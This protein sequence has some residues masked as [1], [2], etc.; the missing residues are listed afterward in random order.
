MRIVASVF[1][2][3][4]FIALCAV[5]EPAEAFPTK[6]TP[7]LT[8]PSLEYSGNIAIA[9]LNSDTMD[10]IID[11]SDYSNGYSAAIYYQK[12]S[13]PFSAP[14]DR[15][16]STGQDP[17]GT[18]IG[19]LNNDTLNDVIIV[20]RQANRIQ[21]HYQNPDH[22]INESA[23]VTI[24]TG[25]QPTDVEIADVNNDTLNDI[26]CTNKNNGI[27][28]IHYQ[29]DNNT[30]NKTVGLTLTTGGNPYFI[31]TG[32]LNDDGLIDIIAV[33]PGSDDGHIFYQ[34]NDNLFNTT[35]DWTLTS[36]GTPYAV[37]IEDMNDDDLNDIVI[38]DL[39]TVNPLFLFYQ[40]NDNTFSSTPD[41]TISI[42]R[43]VRALEVGDLN[44][45][46]LND[47]VA[48]NAYDPFYGF[49]Y[50]QNQD[51]TMPS[52]PDVTLT[53]GNQPSSVG[54]GYLNDDSYI[55]IAITHTY[56]DD[57]R[58][59]FGE[60][61]VV[62]QPPE[63]KILFPNGG[64]MLSGNL[65]ILWNG[66]D[67]D[68][69][70]VD[71]E[72]YLST[73]GGNTWG[74]PI[75]NTT[76]IE[77]PT[78]IT[79]IWDQFNT[80]S[81]PDSNICLIKITAND[82]MGPPVEVN[83]SSFFIIDNNPPVTNHD[84]NGLW[85]SSDFQITL[86]ATDAGSG[87]NNTFYM[88]NGGPINSVSVNG[89][90]QI[91]TEGTA[92]TLEYWSDDNVFNLE[93]HNLLM[94]IKL[95]KTQPTSSDDYDDLWHTSAFTISLSAFDGLSG[96]D[97]IYYRIN[98]GPI[99]S[100]SVNGPPQIT[101]EG[102]TNTLEYW[103]VD[104]ASN[105]EVHN[106]LTDIK[107][108]M[109]PP[110]TTDDYDG[111]WHNTPFTINLSASDNG[112]GVDETYYRI[113]GGPIN[114]V[115]ADGQPQI[116]TEGASNTLEYWSVDNILNEEIHKMLM[117]IKL[118]MTSPTSSDDY[119]GLWHNSS[120]TIN[121]SAIDGLSGVDD[122]YYRINGG[123]I[124]SVSVD[125]QPQITTEGASNTLEY[126]SVD[127][128]LNEEI[129]NIL[130]DIKL[131][132]TPPIT[133]PDYDGL[134]HNS[135]FTIYLSA[136][137]SISGIDEIYY[138][139]NGGPINS[140]S[141]D[142]QPIITTEGA[143]NTLEYWSV[144]NASNE[145]IHNLLT[146]IKF[147]TT[148]PISIHDYD[149]EWN[150]MMAVINLAAYDDLSGVDDIFYR[151][152]NGAV[153]SRKAH[154]QPI[155][156]T[157]GNANTLEFWAVDN[158]SNEESPHNFI[159]D[160]KLDGIIPCI[161]LQTPANCSHIPAGRTIDFEIVETY[162][163][164][165]YYSF[166]DQIYE[167]LYAPYNIFTAGW[168]D[169]NYTI[170]IRAID[171]AGNS[172]LSWYLLTIDSVSPQILLNSPLNNSINYGGAVLDFF[173]FDLNLLHVNSSVNGS[174]DLVILDPFDITTTG[175]P[176][177]DYT[178]QINAVD[179]AGNSKSSWYLFTLDSTPPEILFDTNL[180]HSTVPV[181][182]IIQ[183]DISDPHLS[184]TFCS[185]DGGDFD[186]F[187][188]P[189]ILNTSGWDH[190]IHTIRVSADDVVGNEKTVF[191][192]ITVDAISP[193]VISTDPH[194]N[195]ENIEIS[196]IITIT[197][198]EPMNVT[199]FRDCLYISTSVEFVSYWDEAKEVL[200]ISFE[201]NNLA[202]AT[203]YNITIDSRL[204]DVNGN[205]MADDFTLAFTTEEAPTDSGDDGLL[206]GLHCLW[207]LLLLVIVIVI[208]LL[209]IL[210]GMK[211]KKP[212]ESPD[213]KGREVAFD[214]GQEDRPSETKI[215]PIPPPLKELP[216]PPPPEEGILPPPPPPPPPPSNP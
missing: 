13:P 105:E 122:I 103:S 20:S 132:T 163:N 191:F 16:L 180:N 35:S 75:Y 37:R 178:V 111:L 83:S 15:T 73:D 98:G 6:T 194:T 94:N 99:Y 153:L 157:Q 189:Y 125:G 164:N 43:G 17:Q 211:R 183:M 19:D 161:I 215:S 196:C 172:N 79:H 85:H 32:D 209:I 169:G 63:V 93:D 142:G 41:F 95:D 168:E 126:W 152:N 39:N 110:K 160:I 140:V 3:G 69:D 76:Y 71:Y 27:I 51:N 198:N 199:N 55:D 151:I 60:S 52:S 123:P 139:I 56:S 159:N 136:L 48:V 124:N 18:D 8:V 201:T 109:N 64:E 68:S 38:G 67:A 108:D 181:G 173:I 21:I 210:L 31:D 216:P 49:I 147:D 101:T 92:N 59:Y 33:R 25:S 137:D 50:F 182:R 129:H 120:F 177:G 119:D 91:T 23:D 9:D 84:Y 80:T 146:E 30:I 28:V 144:D 127:N 29:E 113:N 70:T 149:G 12:V 104:N 115:S 46:G 106:M 190:G 186:V 138:R 133:S 135:P 121:L 131:D 89:H 170:Y 42:T 184:G 155:I 117:D 24:N 195:S 128:I 205:P 14:Q 148:P 141:V 165:T 171:L 7:D 97:D 134:W 197:F 204:S 36:I 96:I 78:E 88:I 107:L 130:T 10:D 61:V 203:A 192:D 5:P 154:G 213:T 82:H 102:A 185:L 54:I 208:I 116:A 1:I 112:S 156:T 58:I 26:V 166:D 72:I 158:I 2:L 47:I 45:D 114:S 188:S 53:V 187:A 214:M 202:F 100:V 206:F 162:L 207:I 179:L 62:N 11:T 22:T 200:Y 193:Y 4:V 212:Q 90:P 74:T 34:R 66:S 176:D 175:W 81:F 57:I 143:A 87:V 86:I 167:E 40:K 65:S 44:R 77:S 174:S 145:E 150:I 118:D